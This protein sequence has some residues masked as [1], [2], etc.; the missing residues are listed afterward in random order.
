MK[1]K[2]YEQDIRDVLVDKLTS[3][4]GIRIYAGENK[5]KPY[6]PAVI[7]TQSDISVVKTSYDSGGWHHAR[8]AFDVNVYTRGEN[9]KSLAQ[10][11]A[12]DVIGHMMDMGF[13]LESHDPN[14]GDSVEKYERIVMRFSAIMYTA[15]DTT[16]RG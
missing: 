11:I 8:Y 6:Y 9:A 15:T 1:V 10:S 16:F 7:V 14:L 3:Y 5:G 2:N 4:D 12:N 13:Q